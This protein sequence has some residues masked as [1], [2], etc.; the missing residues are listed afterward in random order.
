MEKAESIWFDGDSW[1]SLSRELKLGWVKGFIEG[2]Y[3]TRMENYQ[4]LLAFG[5]A[6]KRRCEGAEK[7]VDRTVKDMNFMFDLATFL[8]RT[9]TLKGVVKVDVKVVE[10]YEYYDEKSGKKRNSWME[11]KEVTDEWIVIELD[12]FYKDG[13][14]KKVPVR[15]A[16]YIIKL[17]LAGIL[18]EYIEPIIR[19]LRMSLKERI[20]GRKEALLLI[21]SQEYSNAVKMCGKLL[22]VSVSKA[23]FELIA[24]TEQ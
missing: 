4:Y 12:D 6:V 13:R 22:P 24:I 14:N 17:K 1:K 21:E 9:S 3:Q 7:W 20:E 18:Q 10:G 19:L 11:K 8:P 16:I 15:E 2:I 23:F 5:R